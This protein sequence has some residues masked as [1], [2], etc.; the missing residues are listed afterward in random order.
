MQKIQKIRDEANYCLN[1]KVKPCS[2]KG[3]P[4]SNNIPEFIQQIKKENYEKAY[5]ILSETTVLP[6]VCGKICPHFKQCQGSCIRGIKGEPVSIG[7]L[8]SFVFE[9]AM[10]KGGHNGMKNIIAHL[11]SQVFPRIKVGVGEKPAKYDL[12]DYVLGH[13]SKGEAKLM[14]EGYDHAVHAV[15]LIVSGQINEAMNEYNRKKKEEK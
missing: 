15:E 1:C 5:E 8:E 6:G 2:K 4:L 3:C 11:G 12:A 7:K 10:E 14:D 13:F 9:Q